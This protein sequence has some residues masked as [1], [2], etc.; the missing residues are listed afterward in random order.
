[1]ANRPYFISITN[2]NIVYKKETCEFK[3]FTGFAIT[4]KQKSINSLHQEILKRH[5]GAKILEVS[6]KSEDEIGTRLSAFNLKLKSKK[7]GKL[8]PIENIFQSSKVFETGGAYKDLLYCSPKDAKRDER[9]KQSG[10]LIAFNF[11]NKDWPL[12]PKTF[13]YDHI[14]MRALLENE[15]LINQIVQYDTF[16]DIEFNPE[17]SFACQARSVAIFVS[18]YRAKLIYDYIHDIELFKTLYNAEQIAI[19]EQLLLTKNFNDSY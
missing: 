5:P 1:M 7:D 16:T 3:F 14:Y 15:Y 2:S 12:E 19:Q 4:Q 13:F 18:L 10:R 11:E 6:R 9:L 17:K 8:Y